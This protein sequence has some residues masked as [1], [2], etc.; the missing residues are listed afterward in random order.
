MRTENMVKNS[1]YA[2]VAQFVTVFMRAV[3][4]I[5]FVRTLNAEYLGINGLFSNILTMLSLAELGVGGAILFNL[6]SP[7]AEH[8]EKRIKALMNFYKGTYTKIGFFVLL[9]GL[10]LTPFIDFFIKERPNIDNLELIFVLYILNNAL[11][12]FCIYKQSILIANQQNYIV[13]KTTIFKDL[14]MY[15][16]QIVTLL[17]MK[18]FFLYLI[19]MVIA[20]IV[21]NIV[22]SKIA[23]RRYPY[24]INNTEKLGQEERK[25]IYKDVYASMAHRIGGVV[26]FGTDNLLIS[27]F[28]GVVTVGI[29]SNYVFVLS[30]VK[31]FIS[32]LYDALVASI[33]DLVNTESDDKIY[34]VYRQLYFISFC[35]SSFIAIGFSCLVNPLVKIIFGEDYLLPKYIVLLIAVNFYFTDLAAMRAITNKFKVAQGL[36]WYDRHK[37]YIES[38]INLVASI[39]LLKIIGLPGVLLGTFISTICT[40]F[41]IEPFVLYKYGFKRSISNYFLMYF[42]YTGV[43]FLTWIVTEFL[44]FWIDGVWELVVGIFIC[45]VVPCA[46]YWLVFQNTMEFQYLKQLVTN[47]A[48]KC[49]SMIRD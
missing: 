23:D 44:T 36:F 2:I 25:K 20:T 18:N 12:Y 30:A 42:K 10:G 34:Q 17:T 31:G 14:F 47:I 39:I 48:S 7:V 43:F 9:V 24:I 19:V 37:P 32:K 46:S 45:L 33:G 11:S 6:Y 1:Y 13:F 5:I 40:G 26:V 35:I 3:T 21:G 16:I 41:W 27:R 4:Q 28:I 29:Y 22:N 8:N 38:V 49:T 15:A